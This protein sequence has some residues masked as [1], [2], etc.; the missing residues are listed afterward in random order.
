M[1]WQTQFR[2]PEHFYSEAGSRFQDIYYPVIDKETGHIELEKDELQRKNIY[3]EIQSHKDSVDLKKIVERYR[4]GDVSALQRV[5]GFFADI[6]AVPKNVFE[7]MEMQEKINDGF[8]RL[9]ADV[10]ERFDNSVWNYMLTAESDPVE[11]FNR[12]NMSAPAAEEE[13]GESAE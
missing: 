8:N 9:P 5:Q 4:A 6:T 11:W 2:K 1:T 12:H 10:K 13:K 3:E 7:Y